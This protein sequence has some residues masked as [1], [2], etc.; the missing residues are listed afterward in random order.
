M[1]RGRVVVA[2]LAA[3]AVLAGVAVVI[4]DRR[5]PGDDGPEAGQ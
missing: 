5:R 2:V 3:A 1:T 4:G